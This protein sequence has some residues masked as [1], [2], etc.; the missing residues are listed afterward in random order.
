M[1]RNLHNG[2][3]EDA[4]EKSGLPLNNTGYGHG[5]SVGD[6]NNDGFSDLFITRYGS[7]LLYVNQGNGCFVNETDKWGVDIVRVELKEITPPENVQTSMNGVI[8]AQNQ[9]MLL[10]FK[11]KANSDINNVELI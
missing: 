10:S 2:T 6:I 11:F 8:M 4:T 5:V 1:F 9:K 7:Y 3:F